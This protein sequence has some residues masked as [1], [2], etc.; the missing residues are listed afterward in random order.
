M[1]TR[2]QGD[3]SPPIQGKSDLV[4]WIAEGAKPKEKWRIGTEHEKFGFHTDTLT[5]L[6]YEGSRGVKALLEEMIRRF[7]WEPILEGD[8]I[9]ALKRPKGDPFGGNISLEPGGQFELSGGPLETLHQTCREADQHLTQVREIGAA[10][11]IGFLGLG[12]SPK[13]TLPETP[14]MPKGRYKIMRNYMPKVGSQGL[15]MMF[16]TCTVQVNLDFSSEADMVKKFR[17]SVALQPVVTAIF[18]NA[19]F[20]EGKPNGFLSL[21]SEIW[22]DTDNQR[23]GMVP[24]IFEPGMSYERYVDWA[25]D[26][27]MYFFYRDGKYIDMTDTTF[28]QMLDG[29]NRNRI[30]GEPT[31]D[32]WGDHLTT[33]FPEAR[34][35]KYLEMRGADGGPW[36]RLYTLPA[37]W[38][39]LLYDQSALD[40]AWDLVKDWTA[41]ERQALRDGVPKSALKTPFRGTTV[42]EIAREVLK[43]SRGGLRARAKLDGL[44]SDETNFLDPIDTRLAAGTTAAEDLLER[45]HKEWGGN[46]DRIFREYTF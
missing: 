3:A 44:G 4:H 35:K 46:I 38:V 1:S 37:V 11:G 32:D 45:Y 23:S 36:R 6:P 41:A 43:I 27:P 29:R 22:R 12:S 5:P 30:T 18:A 31:I 2:E 20:T 21:R 26:V 9:I 13:W 14:V 42:L 8:N 40:A 24:F 16:R 10:L 39:G 17:T 33:L 19:P 25:L 7:G 15:E 28:R 34:L